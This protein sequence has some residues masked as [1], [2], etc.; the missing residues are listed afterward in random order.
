MVSLTRK[1]TY[2]SVKAKVGYCVAF[3]LVA[4][5][6]EKPRI[7]LQTQTPQ[8]SQGYAPPQQLLPSRNSIC[9]D[10]CAGFLIV[11]SRLISYSLLNC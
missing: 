4:G 5:S 8:H 10:F 6:K 9:I 2:K 7:L 1:I 11:R 3:D